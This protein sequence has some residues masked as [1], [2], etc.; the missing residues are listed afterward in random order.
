MTLEQAEAE[1]KRMTRE[2]TFIDEIRKRFE[3]K[4]TPTTKQRGYIDQWQSANYPMELIQYAYEIT[5]ENIEKCDFKYIDTILR[6]WAESGV[7]ERKDAEA[8]REKPR[9]AA[10]KTGKST[11]PMTQREVD[12]MNSY[13]SAVNRFKKEDSDE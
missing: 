11:K 7:R 1:I 4:R 3:L 10:P 12:K 2:H 8:L 9:S 13:L 5:V 6:G